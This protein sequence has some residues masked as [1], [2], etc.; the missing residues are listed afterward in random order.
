MPA[1][2]GFFAER[3]KALRDHA[4]LSQSV[5]AERSGVAISTIRQFEYG[6]REPT[7][8]TL[9]KLAKGLGVSLSAFEQEEH[10][11][12]RR[13]GPPKPAQPSGQEA[14]PAAVPEKPPAKKA[15][16]RTKGK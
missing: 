15:R 7:Y 5:L 10:A 2:R 11:P 9:V 16:G 3:L 4:A 6:R 14:P 1:E 8:G 13:G 12:A